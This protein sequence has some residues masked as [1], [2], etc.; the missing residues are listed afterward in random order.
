MNITVNKKAEV[1]GGYDVVVC[2]GGPSGFISAIAAAREGA[3]VALVEKYGFIGGMP[4]AALVNPISRF[5]KSGELVIRGI[6][7]EFVERLA[8]I[9]GTVTDYATGHAP[10]D[11]EKYKI[12]A[13]RMVLEA[14]V[15]LYLHSVVTDVIK[16]DK[17]NISHIVIENKSGSVAL[18]AGYVI[19]CTGDADVAFKAGVP[20]LELPTI[21]EIQPASLCFRL[22]G[23]KLDDVHG[24]HPSMLGVR[25]EC[26]EVREGLLA[27]PEDE[28]VP[29]FGGPWFCTIMNDGPGICGVNITRTALDATDGES[30][31]NAELKLREDVHTF[32]AL[33]KKHFPAFKD[34]YLLMTA[35]QVGIRE[36]RRIRS[37]H[38]LTTEEYAEGVDFPDS[39]ARGAHPIDIHKA[40][41]SS[42]DLANLNNAP[43]IPYSTQY[44]DGFDNLLVA[45][46]CIGTERRPL[47]SLRV[48]ATAMALG[49]SAGTAAAIAS[50]NKLGVSEISI[51]EL[52]KTL[53]DNGAIL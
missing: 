41:G 32:V 42:Q 37:H 34:C 18:E 39:V 31:T 28:H 15:K 25:S 13:Q 24:V 38:I 53:L 26:K 20:M 43:H 23:V 19:D 47:A 30:M 8:E 33:L 6:P 35:T 22:G 16:D 4:T 11:P 12:V 48:Q 9:G 14:G 7:F 36:S 46:R 50:R 40:G 52:R 21:D 3:S 1:I 49:Q 5:R 45:G 10:F 29:E 51:A 17:N 44:A 27:L 2:G